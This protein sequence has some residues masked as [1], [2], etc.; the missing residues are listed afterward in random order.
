MAQKKSTTTGFRKQL[1]AELQSNV[2]GGLKRVSGNEILLTPLMDVYESSTEFTLVFAVPGMGK[3]DV[4]VKI[5]GNE[6]I[7]EE[8][9][10]AVKKAA[11]DTV[12]K[13]L[14]NGRYF[15]RVL[16]TD[17]IEDKSVNGTIDK[18]LLT[19]TLKKSAQEEA[20]GDDADSE[21]E[22]G[23]ILKRAAATGADSEDE[24]GGAGSRRGRVKSKP[25]GRK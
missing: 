3:E 12:I 7:V 14:E 18:G 22:N 25:R 17:E 2:R 13:E 9:K 19:I 20:E 23:S 5:V 6:L 8:K 10:G 1:L 24:N 16:L 4:D 11:G 21:D 15:R